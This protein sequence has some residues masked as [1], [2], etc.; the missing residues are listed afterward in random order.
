MEPVAGLFDD[1]GLLRHPAGRGA[2][3]EARR[4]EVLPVED[5]K[6]LQARLAEMGYPVGKVDG[7]IGGA[8][9]AAIREVQLKSGLPA[10]AWP[11]RELLAA[12]R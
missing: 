4:C 10:D 7:I 12:V 5:V 8:T 9:R 1:G 11:T 2:E 6:A 3:A